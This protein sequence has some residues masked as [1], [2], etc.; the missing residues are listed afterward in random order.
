[1]HARTW[2]RP[3]LV[4]GGI[5]VLCLSLP[6]CMGIGAKPQANQAACTDFTFPVYFESGSD[7]LTTEA[8]QLISESVTRTKGC[9]TA[10]MSISG[11]GQDRSGLGARRADAVT[12]ALMANGVTTPPQVVPPAAAPGFGLLHRSID[13]SVHYVASP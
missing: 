13:V 5:A 12:K 4:A 11:L 1:M 8:V 6:A 2:V 9:P 10:M 7:Q 3:T